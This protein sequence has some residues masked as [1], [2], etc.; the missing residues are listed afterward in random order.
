MDDR[1]RRLEGIE[2]ETN[3]RPYEPAVEQQFE[4]W[5]PSAPAARDVD[6][7]PPSRQV[8][9]EPP[10]SADPFEEG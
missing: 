5:T 10:A 3:Q 7:A 4:P 8:S 1:D 9:G 6:E 2:D